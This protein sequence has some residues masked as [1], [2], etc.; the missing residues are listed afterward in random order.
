MASPSAPTAAPAGPLILVLHGWRTNA[1]VIRTQTADLFRHAAPPHARVVYL[2]APHPAGGPAHAAVEAAFPS[3]K[4]HGGWREWYDCVAGRE[5]GASPEYRGLDA[6]L[7]FVEG[8]LRRLCAG[9]TSASSIVLCGFSQGGTIAALVALRARQRREAAHDSAADAVPPISH[10]LLLCAMPPGGFY[11]EYPEFE[12]KPLQIPTLHCVG[13]R[14]P[15]IVRSEEF[16]ARAF[17][18]STSSVYMHSGNHKPPSVFE[19]REGTFDAVRDFLAG[20]KV[21]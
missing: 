9:P 15:M 12:Q 1:R 8:E 13:T 20:G 3:C 5:E 7:D 2:D 4:A 10:L 19:E 14:D 17:D 16:A 18:A 11:A 6:S 21:S